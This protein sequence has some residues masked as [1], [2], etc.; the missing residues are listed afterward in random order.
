[1][2]PARLL[3]SSLF[4]HHPREQRRIVGRLKKN[5]GFGQCVL[6]FFELRASDQSRAHAP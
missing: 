4:E 1:M 2:I 6:G 5:C 3:K